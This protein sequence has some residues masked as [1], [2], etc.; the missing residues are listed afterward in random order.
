[1]NNQTTDEQNLIDIQ[2]FLDRAPRINMSM[3]VKFNATNEEDPVEFGEPVV[4]ENET[5]VAISEALTAESE[6]RISWGV[7]T[8][9]DVPPDLQSGF[10]GFCNMAFDHLRGERMT[11]EIL[12][13]P[14]RLMSVFLEGIKSV[15]RVTDYNVRFDPSHSS[16]RL[17]ALSYSVAVTATNSTWWSNKARWL[18]DTFTDFILHPNSPDI[19]VRSVDVL[20]KWIEE[21]IKIL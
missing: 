3:V 12:M 5:D 10:N 1:M 13:Q 2:E 17:S 20:S 8:A 6:S 19:I 7:A 14:V 21:L 4:V 18:W 15:G 11:K 9:G 16:H